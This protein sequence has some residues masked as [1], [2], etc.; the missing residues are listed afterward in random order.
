MPQLALEYSMPHMMVKS[1]IGLT[2]TPAVDVSVATGSKGFI[3]GGACSFATSANEL[4][5]WS[6]GAGYVCPV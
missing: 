5:T 3:V 1:N 6:V 2:A 4:K